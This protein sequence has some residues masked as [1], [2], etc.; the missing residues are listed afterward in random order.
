MKN[1]LKVVQPSPIAKFIGEVTLSY[2]YTLS[3]DSPI[4]TQGYLNLNTI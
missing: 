2:N 4:I 3:I 1:A